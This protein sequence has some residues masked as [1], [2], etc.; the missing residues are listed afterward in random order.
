MLKYKGDYYDTYI[1]WFCFTF[2]EEPR[3]SR[4][5][6]K[7]QKD[8]YKVGYFKPVGFSPAVVEERL[9]TRMQPFFLRSWR[10]MNRRNQ[11]V[12]LC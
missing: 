3:L 7:I 5:W 2:S 1:Y 9:Q 4:S 12:L 10:Q 11:S 6:I 8:G